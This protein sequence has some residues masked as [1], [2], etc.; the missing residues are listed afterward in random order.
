M[1]GIFNIGKLETPPVFSTIGVLTRSLGCDL[2]TTI[3]VCG[4]MANVVGD[5]CVRICRSI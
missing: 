2:R 4:A 5:C 1:I 3:G